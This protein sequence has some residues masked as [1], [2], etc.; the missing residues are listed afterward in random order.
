M[1]AAFSLVAQARNTGTLTTAPQRVITDGRRLLLYDVVATD[2]KA[3]ALLISVVSL[4]GHRIDG[5]IGLHG[6]ASEWANRFSA[7]VVRLP[8]SAT[9]TK[10]FR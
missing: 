3:T 7:A 1:P 5:V 8:S 2:P 4:S 6:E 10:N 9:A